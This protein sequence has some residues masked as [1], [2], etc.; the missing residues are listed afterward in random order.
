MIGRTQPS[1]DLGGCVHLRLSKNEYYRVDNLCIYILS[2]VKDEV[3]KKGRAAKLIPKLG[4]EERDASEYS[5][6]QVIAQRTA[7]KPSGG[8]GPLVPCGA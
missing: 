8:L 5:E 1:E 7:A 4:N 6:A 3:N 2:L